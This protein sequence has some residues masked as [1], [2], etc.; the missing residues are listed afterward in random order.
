MSGQEN[1]PDYIV[2]NGFIILFQGNRNPRGVLY[3]PFEKIRM[4]MFFIFVTRLTD[5]VIRTKNTLKNG[6]IRL[7]RLVTTKTFEHEGFFLFTFKGKHFEFHGLNHILRKLA[8]ADRT[9]VFSLLLLTT[10]IH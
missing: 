10:P 2:L 5:L 1:R 8:S 4:G 9:G 6:S 7:G 3:S